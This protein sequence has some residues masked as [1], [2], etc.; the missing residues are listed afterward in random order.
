MVCKVPAPQNKAM[1]ILQLIPMKNI[2]DLD[3]QYRQYLQTVGLSESQMSEGQRRETKRAFIAG[4][5]AMLIL[6]R[7]NI[8][9]MGEEKAIETLEKMTKDVSDFFVI[10]SLNKN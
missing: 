8:P 4:L 6:F 7:N 3:Y 2:F 5:G 1:E 9:Q 10:E